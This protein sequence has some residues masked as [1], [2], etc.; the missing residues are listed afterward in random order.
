MKIFDGHG[1]LF[2]HF[3]VKQQK[4]ESDVFKQYH[5]DK[6]RKGNV[7][8]GV[9]N[10]WIDYEAIPAKQRAMEI[11]SYGIKEVLESDYIEMVYKYNEFDLESDKIQFI[12]G[13]EGIDYL[14]NAEDIYM[15]Y[16]YGARLIS[17]TWNHNNKF[18]S[19][20]TSEVDTGLTNEGRKA[21]EIMD[22]LGIVI[23]I[24][25]LSDD[26]AREIIELSKNPVIASHSNAREICAHK[27]NLP[28]DLIHAVAASGGIIGMNSFVDVVST[29]EA[30]QNVEGLIEHIDYIKSLVGI[31]HIALG[32]DFMDY[33]MEDSPSEF[34][35][36]I[37]YMSDLKNQGDI[38]TLVEGLRNHGYS[39]AELEKICY[40]NMFR[41]LSK[42]I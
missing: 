19:S 6:F 15:M 34:I 14:D 9:F 7:N 29:D 26:S 35:E 24:S 10:I 3:T 42:I 36:D 30:K 32:F 40:K 1:D 12:M 41:V 8:F 31:E 39:E 37:S 20:I 21:I 23:D 11:M 33:L 25:H 22:E 27:R 38:Q 18:A 13:L 2:A 28:D 5:L 4:G 17:L 16:Q